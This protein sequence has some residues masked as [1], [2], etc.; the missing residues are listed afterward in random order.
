MPGGN[1]AGGGLKTVAYK[2]KNSMLHKG[3]KHGEPIQMNYSAP[4][5]L[6]VSKLASIVGDIANVKK[7]MDNKKNPAP[8]K[9][10]TEEVTVDGG[11]A[12]KSQAQ[13]DYNKR[14]EAKAEAAY[15][16]DRASRTGGTNF[17][18]ATDEVRNKYMAQA[19]KT[20]A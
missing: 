10:V 18:T 19:Q 16:K 8:N 3:A 11:K 4:T 7:T 15:T 12:G 20:K 2:M 9:L 13:R 14:L 17:S 1:K 6:D 5:K